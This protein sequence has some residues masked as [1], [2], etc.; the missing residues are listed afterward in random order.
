MLGSGG[1]RKSF[2][3][4]CVRKGHMV[5]CRIHP[6]IYSLPGYDCETCP[7]AA[8]AKARDTKNAKEEV[9]KKV[10]GSKK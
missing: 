6:T 8:K 10:S 7:E 2:S 3:T 4:N 9:A 1:C 5:K